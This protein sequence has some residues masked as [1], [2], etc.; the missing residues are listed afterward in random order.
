MILDR[1]STRSPG[2]S[3]PR[4]DSRGDDR[5]DAS[6]GPAG[7]E[8]LKAEKR[9]L[10]ARLAEL[11]K[12]LAPPRNGRGPDGPLGP[13]GAAE[14]LLDVLQSRRAA[15]E[16]ILSTPGEDP[17]R[18]LLSVGAADEVAPTAREGAVTVDLAGAGEEDPN[19]PTGGAVRRPR[20]QPTEALRGPVEQRGPRFEAPGFVQDQTRAAVLLE[21]Q[22]WAGEWDET[23]EQ[24][25]RVLERSG[26]PAHERRAT[27][28]P[29]SGLEGGP[30]RTVWR[31]DRSRRYGR[32][33]GGDAIERAIR[34]ATDPVGQWTRDLEEG[35]GPAGRPARA[36]RRP[37]DSRDG[38]EGTRASPYGTGERSVP[39][40]SGSGERVRGEGRSAGPWNQSDS[41]T[42]WGPTGGTRGRGGSE[43][44]S[45]RVE[46]QPGPMAHMA[47]SVEHIAR[48]AAQA[49]SLIAELA[50]TKQEGGKGTSPQVALKQFAL[51]GFGQERSPVGL[52]PGEPGQIAKVVR[53]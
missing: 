38:E 6:E 13:E 21:A 15:R 43:G 10:E 44:P 32:G 16:A 27:P 17:T 2:A 49:R 46:E 40:R 31:S 12:A 4:A 28:L 37:Q 1:S 41:R 26:G 7:Q 24:P 53:A 9:K 51:S 45:V 22:R 30:A 11:E 34:L 3:P 25:E 29:A 8:V 20:G 52:T 14:D 23:R 48:A 5:G 35:R 33:P 18:T 50:V 19:G 39:A 47:Q 36:G 42:V